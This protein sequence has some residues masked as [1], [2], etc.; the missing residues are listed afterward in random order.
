M[1]FY[2]PFVYTIA[3]YGDD[4]DNTCNNQLKCHHVIKR[5]VGLSNVYMEH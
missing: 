4:I 2:T 1:L 5:N 3:V